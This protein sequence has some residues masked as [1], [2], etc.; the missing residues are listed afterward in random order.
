MRRTYLYLSALAIL[1]SF[2]SVTSAF[3]WSS[4][5]ITAYWGFDNPSISSLDLIKSYN[6]STQVAH[7]NTTDY[8]FGNSY[9]PRGTD[10]SP[11]NFSLSKLGTSNLTSCFWLK[12]IGVV[13]GYDRIF[14]NGSS[15]ANAFGIGFGG[16]GLN[17]ALCSGADCKGSPNFTMTLNKWHYI[18]VSWNEYAGKMRGYDNGT[19]IQEWSASI[20][21]PKNNF[22]FFGYGDG[23]IIAQNFTIDELSF[24]N[25]SLS[26]ADIS[27][28]YN[29]GNGLQYSPNT[30][31]NV[32]VNKISPQNSTVYS[33]RDVSFNVSLTPAY[34]N[35]T[36]ATIY[37]ASVDANYTYNSTNIVTGN[38][39][40]YTTFN[41]SGLSLGHYRW[42]INGCARNNTAS[43]CTQT[44]NST[45]IVGA[46]ILNSS[47][48]LN[49]YETDD[50]TFGITIQLTTGASLLLAKLN[51][52]GTEYDVS[53]ITISENNYTLSKTI[54]LP[55]ISPSL[56][57]QNFSFYWTFYYSNSVITNQQSATY[58]QTVNRATFILCNGTY[59]TQALN[60]TT[61]DEQ[62]L[63][64]ISSSTSGFFEYWLGSGGI[65]KN[66]TYSNLT[67]NPSYK[68]CISPNSTYHTSADV[69]FT[70]TGY[71]D[72]E[73]HLVNTPLTNVSNNIQV[74]MLLSSASTKFF[75]TASNVLS[76][77]QN[78]V[79][80]IAKKYSDGITRT[81]TTKETD[82]NGGFTIYLDQD[83]SYTYF[84]GNESISKSAICQAAPC[85]LNLLYGSSSSNTMNRYY[86]LYAVGIVSNLSYD[87]STKIVTYTFQD[88][89]GTA[90]YFRLVVSKNAYGGIASA[91]VCDQ[92]LNS[93][94]GE[95]T[96]NL[97]G[98]SGDFS[99]RSYISRS[100]EKL[101]QIINIVID[102]LKASFGSLQ[103]VFGLAILFTLVF[104][105]AA[106]SGGNPTVII[107]FFILGIVV[108][109]IMSLSPFSWGFIALVILVS[110]MLMRRLMT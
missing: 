52:N 12:R 103:L 97:T 13:N 4:S 53:N 15:D 62:N 105:G 35:L 21:I 98:Y 79:I 43:V 93:V 37:I 5:N 99:V 83:E 58:N 41:V 57:N 96:C 36:N 24:F 73:Y 7:Y 100:P 32:S 49:S 61:V 71:N 28:L 76:P 26:D 89:L 33:T 25:A 44:D 107:F 85:T 81:I 70:S 14:T 104:A 110:G 11:T 87:S 75:I 90:N 3:S 1:I 102:E 80:T 38:N 74:A 31:I 34:S 50:S 51:Y 9:T 55:A 108:P 84:Y 88:T 39:T 63:T 8:I 54:D 65:K 20:S 6:I 66:Y 95:I 17:L 23:S 91:S 48:D 30:A 72:G 78:T 82:S 46:T 109:K 60:F 106:V 77:L 92:T 16:T 68:F 2:I 18:C 27:S 69:Y 101:D 67:V 40:N 45:F 86:D 19:F 94:A 47:Y 56:T 42:N 59:A 22:T 29:S 64:V 10:L